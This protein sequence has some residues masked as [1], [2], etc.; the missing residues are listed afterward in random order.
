[1]CRKTE[2]SNSAGNLRRRGKKPAAF[3]MRM[4]W[5]AIGLSVPH[6]EFEHD[7]PHME[8][9]PPSNSTK[10]KCLGP[11][12]SKV[13]VTHNKKKGFLAG[14]PIQIP[15]NWK[16]DGGFETASEVWRWHPNQSQFCRLPIC[17]M[18]TDVRQTVSP[19]HQR[20]GLRHRGHNAAHAQATRFGARARMR[21]RSFAPFRRWTAPTA[22]LSSGPQRIGEIPFP[23]T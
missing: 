1:M 23:L 18:L 3:K 17:R 13:R 21:Q 14:S 15:K 8:E 19:P 11:I 16:Q 12:N 22:P 4:R 20:L 5:T 7:I 2:M 10:N 9:V 6:G